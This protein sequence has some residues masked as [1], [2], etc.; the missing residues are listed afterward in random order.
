MNQSTTKDGGILLVEDNPDDVAMTLRALKKNNINNPVVVAR[1]GLEA[2]DYLAGTGSFAGR[3]QTPAP[4]VIL[5][6]LKL[7]KL[8]GLGVLR[9]IR[10]DSRTSLF[11]VVMLTSSKEEQ[12][13]IASY[14]LGP[15]ATSAN[16]WTSPSLLRRCANWGFTGS[17]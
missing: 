16:R 5:L 12:D 4:L 10:E 2:L 1:D 13:L 14:R 7:P 3:G 15:T 9:R 11:P 17:C 8:D 6:D